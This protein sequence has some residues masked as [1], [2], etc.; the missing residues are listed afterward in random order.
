MAADRPRKG[1]NMH[2]LAIN[3]SHL[4]DRVCVWPATLDEHESDTLHED[5]VA[6]ILGRW[7]R[8]PRL[9]DDEYLREI[10]VLANA[11]CDRAFDEGWL[12]FSPED[13]D[14]SP[15]QQAVNELARNLRQ[16]H[17]EGDG[18]LEAAED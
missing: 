15:L 12:T 18:C 16:V 5:Q 11:V 3:V 10:E 9:S 4:G 8:P 6:G 17:H 2:D 7:T 1:A 14:Q 13:D